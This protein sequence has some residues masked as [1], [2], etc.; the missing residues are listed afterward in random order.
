M[1]LNVFG[2][3]FSGASAEGGPQRIT[4]QKAKEMMRWPHVKRNWIKAIKAIRAGGVFQ[5]EYIWWNIKRDLIPCDNRRGLLRKQ[6]AQERNRKSHTQG[7]QK[8]PRLT[9]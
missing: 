6:T 4:P 9:A 7:F 2:N 3:L 1:N 8:A 5:K